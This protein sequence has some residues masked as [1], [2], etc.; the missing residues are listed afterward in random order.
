MAQLALLTLGDV[1]GTYNSKGPIQSDNRGG[2]TYIPIYAFHHEAAAVI[3]VK[4]GLP[5]KE[6]K[7]HPIVITKKVDPS[8]PVIHERYKN[9]TLLA[10]WD[11]KL[12][13]IPM[14]GPNAHYF[15]IKLAGARIVGIRLRKPSL[16]R[17]VPGS[18]HE[19]EEISFTY[20]TITWDAPA[21]PVGLNHG[22]TPVDS[23]AEKGSF[24]P[25]WA[26]EKARA[27]VEKLF[28]M[29][30]ERV[31]TVAKAQAVAEGWM[32]EEK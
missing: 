24:T 2:P 32:S 23:F 28:G 9:N 3:D 17:Q 30:A 15:S 18:G 8:S 31:K 5:T 25:D 21:S 22:N 4:T 7:H 14:S 16:T 11:L 19:V 10:P 20:D 13:H 12:F 6:I 29:L 1:E 26:E 27:A